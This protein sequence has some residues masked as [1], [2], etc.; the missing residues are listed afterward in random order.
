MHSVIIVKLFCG[1]SIT[2]GNKY[3]DIS[4]EAY[5]VVGCVREHLRPMTEGYLCTTGLYQEARSTVNKAYILIT[6]PGNSNQPTKNIMKFLNIL[7]D[8]IL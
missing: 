4:T 6:K 3:D 7:K 8:V 1:N 5:R 2:V